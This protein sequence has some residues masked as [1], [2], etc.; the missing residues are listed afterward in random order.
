MHPLTDALVALILTFGLSVG[1]EAILCLWTPTD[2]ATV[3]LNFTFGFPFDVLL[4]IDLLTRSVTGDVLSLILGLPLSVVMWVDGWASTS[5]LMR[6]LETW[7]K[8][9]CF[10]G[11]SG[12]ILADP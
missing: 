3:A 5:T 12:W 9:L 4:P 2:N 8:Y 10:H 7:R 1:T 6:F 11:G